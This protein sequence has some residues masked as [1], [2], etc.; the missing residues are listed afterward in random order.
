MR[1]RMVPMESVRGLI[2]SAAF[3]YP[4]ATRSTS[5]RSLQKSARSLSVTRRSNSLPGIV[6]IQ[7]STLE[8]SPGAIQSCCGCA[9][10]IRWRMPSM[11]L[12]SAVTTGSHRWW[13]SLWDFPLKLMRTRT[14]RRSSSHG[15]HGTD[16]ST[17]TVF[18][19]SRGLLLPEYL[20]V[21]STQKPRSFS[22]NS[23]LRAN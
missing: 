9:V 3:W 14:K 13:I 17:Y 1:L 19:R 8:P 12:S 21:R 22:E 4:S 5:V 15:W 11:L 10:A 16:S 20:R 23:R 7:N 2:K 18:F 6:P